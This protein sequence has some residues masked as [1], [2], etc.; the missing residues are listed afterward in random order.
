MRKISIKKSS[1]KE[2]QNQ[3]RKTINDF[4]TAE[5]KHREHVEKIELEIF[6]HLKQHTKKVLKEKKEDSEK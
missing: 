6:E 4:Y 1:K 2:K 5:Q 3:S